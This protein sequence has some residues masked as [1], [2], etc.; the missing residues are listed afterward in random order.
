MNATQQTSD[1]FSGEINTASQTEQERKIQ[2]NS[3][4]TIRDPRR[5]SPF[6]AS[7]LSFLPGLGQVYV[8]YYRRGFQN[9]LIFAACVSFL[10]TWGGVMPLTPLV[11]FF[12]VFFWFYNV[13]DAA[14]R[15]S[16]FNLSLEGIEQIDLPDELTNKPLPVKGSY[17]TGGVLI[18]GG[19]IA[20]SNTLFGFTLDW[21]ED[22]WPVAPVVF[23]AFLVYLA[24]KDE[25]QDAREDS[26]E[27][28]Q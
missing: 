3:M 4:N 20:L 17:I 1:Q 7:I 22:W 21:L 5:K 23:G 18:L 24:W 19:V 9:I 28:S 8:G 13:I 12:M 14:R 11:A 15:A 2:D 6:L 25:H 27:D 26:Q 10:A 16:L